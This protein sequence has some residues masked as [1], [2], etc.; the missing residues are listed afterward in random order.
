MEKSRYTLVHHPDADPA[1]LA[2]I[3]EQI[4]PEILASEDHGEILPRTNHVGPCR[5]CGQIAE[6]TREHIPPRSAF[7][8]ER[9]EFSE[10]DEL[11]EDGL[12]TQPRAGEKIQGGLSGYVLCKSCNN[13]TGTRYAREYQ[14]WAR[15]GVGCLGDIHNSQ[16][17]LDKINEMEEECPVDVSFRDVYPG[18][19]IRQVISMMMCISGGPELGERFPDLRDLALGG[20]RRR[21]QEPLR[22]YCDL[23][24]GPGGRTAGGQYG[25]LVARDSIVR[26]VLEICYPPFA[27]VVLIDGPPDRNIGCDITFFTESDP[28]YK[29]AVD[30]SDLRVCFN[31]SI[32][33]TDYR[34][35]GQIMAN[36]D[37]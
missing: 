2:R 37:R 11:F 32:A 8:K 33:P 10:G 29:T 9:V 22:V 24:A 23:F 16:L 26:R 28:D 35:L 14:E 30:L 20:E 18:R 19:F 5:I 25:H 34:T 7:N 21:L 27:L 1:E 31:N 17:S 4:D 15:R 13:F 3:L 36:R 12:L 6:L